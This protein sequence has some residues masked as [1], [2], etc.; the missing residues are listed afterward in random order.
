MAFLD[1]RDRHRLYGAMTW[2]RRRLRSFLERRFERM[3]MIVG[4]RYG[5]NPTQD[6]VLI[7][8][9]GMAVNIYARKL[10]ASAPRALVTTHVRNL[11]PAATELQA[12]MNNLLAHELRTVETLQNIVFDSLT[13]F[14]IAKV[15][16]HLSPSSE[17]AHGIGHDPGQFYFDHILPDDF[18]VD[19]TAKRWDQ[20]DF[21]GDTY[22]VPKDFVLENRDFDRKAVEKLRDRLRSRDDR[23]GDAER[24]D[25]YASQRLT[26]SQ[27]SPG[28]DKEFIEHVELSDLWLPKQRLLVTVAADDPAMPPLRIVE[29]DGPERGPYNFLMYRPIPGN[30]M[31]QEPVGMWEGL[32]TVVNKLFGKIVEQAY[33]QKNLVGVMAGAEEDAKTIRD[34]HDGDIIPVQTPENIKPFQAGGFDQNN[35]GLTVQLKQLFS[36]VAGNID[37]IGGLGAQTDTVGQDQLLAANASEQVK[38][39]QD[40]TY[41]F[42]KEVLQSMAHYLWT[43]PVSQYDLNYNPEGTS[44]NIPMQWPFDDET[45]EDKREGDF[46]QY[47]FD[48][49]PYSLQA[50]S[51]QERVQ[52]VTSVF[53]NILVPLAPMMQQN[54]QMIDVEAFIKFYAKYSN[55]P[56]L[57]EMVRFLEGELLPDSQPRQGGGKPPMPAQTTR[58][59]ERVSRSAGATHGAESAI[60]ANAMFGGNPQ[61]KEQMAVG[62][63]A[64]A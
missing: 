52:E 43:D 18:V 16:I 58:T 14:G 56:E 50:K 57:K 1:E 47:N 3:Q 17:E 19:M 7:P 30:L 39:M 53:T 24:G 61:P 42:M 12:V 28:T 11:R 13:M 46:L 38:D 62:M 27:D 49:E 41:R 33:R 48:I 5:E 26:S 22:C 40:A 54:G 10:V 63:G 6:K 35:F 29:W 51:P 21:C 55:L 44:V 4:H 25:D 2:S 9:L 23:G 45:G 37:S 8:L 34:A 20:I 15:G 59:Y 36:W 32:H 64:G 31:P 60:I